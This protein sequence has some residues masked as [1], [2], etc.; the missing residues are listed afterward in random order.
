M[1]RHFRGDRVIGHDK[2]PIHT[3]NADPYL[4]AVHHEVVAGQLLR[5]NIVRTQYAMRDLFAINSLQQLARVNTNLNRVPVD[6]DA[7]FKERPGVTVRD[8]I[9]ELK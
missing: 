1:L 7:Y 9:T 8:A 3:S 6:G 2:C 4:Q 5:H